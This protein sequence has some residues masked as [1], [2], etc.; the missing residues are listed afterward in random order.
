ML[1]KSVMDPSGASGF[2]DLLL[3]WFCAPQ[4]VPGTLTA[5]SHFVTPCAYLL[6][7]ACNEH[8]IQTPLMPS[9]N[10]MD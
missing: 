2:M 7:H 10:R 6:Q 9:H 8:A 4:G 3:L 1:S 5:Q